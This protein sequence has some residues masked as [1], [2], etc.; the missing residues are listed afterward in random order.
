[1]SLELCFQKESNEYLFPSMLPI[2][3]ID[4]AQQKWKESAESKL[5]GM[6]YLGRRIRIEDKRLMF[7]P[8]FLPQLICHLLIGFVV[9]D[10]P[11]IWNEGLIFKHSKEYFIGL[12]M[13]GMMESNLQE[14]ES[15]ESIQSISNSRKHGESNRLKMMDILIKG[16]NIIECQILMNTCLKSIEYINIHFYG[17]LKWNQ[18]I[19]F[20]ST[21]QKYYSIVDKRNIFSIPLNEN[22]NNGNNQLQDMIKGEI[23]EEKLLDLN[24]SGDKIDNIKKHL[25]DIAFHEGYFEIIKKI[26]EQEKQNQ[27][28]NNTNEINEEIMFGIYLSCQNG[29]SNILEYVIGSGIQIDFRKTFWN[30][31]CLEIGSEEQNTEIVNIICQFQQDPLKIKTEYQ[32]KYGFPSNLSFNFNL[33]SNLILISFSPK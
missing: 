1:M 13:H 30:K 23:T 26:I 27:D 16:P 29:H 11:Y 28:K 33:S 14:N 8:S 31:N 17:N 19:L 21:I 3:S 20:S 32:R 18:E 25:I 6:K 22:E 12:F 10:E 9:D 7:H 24:N 5:N 4:L 2:N 15:N